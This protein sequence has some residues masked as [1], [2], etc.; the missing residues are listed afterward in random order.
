ML[1][2]NQILMMKKCTRYMSWDWAIISYLSP[3]NSFLGVA[4]LRYWQFSDTERP[5]KVIWD[6]SSWRF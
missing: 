2:N 6:E 5:I 3:S 1:A 4:T